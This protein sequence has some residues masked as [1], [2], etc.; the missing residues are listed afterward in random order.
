MIPRIYQDEKQE[1]LSINLLNLLTTTTKAVQEAN[2]K[3]KKRDQRIEFLAEK[4]NCKDEVLKMLKE[5]D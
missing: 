2:E 5:G 3:I 1:L 4:L